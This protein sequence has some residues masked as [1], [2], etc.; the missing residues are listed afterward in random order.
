M[1][2]PQSQQQYDNDNSRFRIQGALSTL[3]KIFQDGIDQV[4]NEQL[5]HVI[6][7]IITTHGGSCIDHEPVLALQVLHAVIPVFPPALA[8]HVTEYT[9]KLWQWANVQQQHHPEVQSMVEIRTIQSWVCRNWNAVLAVR[10]EH[11]AHQ[12]PR[13]AHKVL[14]WTQKT[15]ST[16]HNKND[17]NNNNNNTM[18]TTA[19]GDD[20]SFLE[21]E[22]C[23]FWLTFCTLDED[24]LSSSF[25]DVVRNPVFLQGL[26]HTLL[27][28]M[29]YDIDKQQELLWM[30]AQEEQEQQ[31]QLLLLL[32]QNGPNPR[33]ALKPIF[34]R[35]RSAHNQHHHH[36]TS[37]NKHDEPSHMLDGHDMN[38]DDDDDDDDDDESSNGRI[39]GMDDD[40]DDEEWTVRKCAAATLDSLAHLYGRDILPILLP[41]ISAGLSA[42]NDPWLQEASILALGAVADGCREDIPHEFM[43]QVYGFLLDILFQS[44]SSSSAIVPPSLVSMAAWT[45]SQFAGFC[46]HQVQSGQDPDLLRKTTDILV[47]RLLHTPSI[48]KV[49]VAVASALAMLVEAA[50]D[51]MAPYLEHLYRSLVV[52]LN[53]FQGRS[54]LTVFDVFGILAEHGGPSTADVQLLSIYVP[55][56]LQMWGMRAQHEPR[57]RILLPLMESLSS[58][59]LAAGGNFTEYALT[60]FDNS[61]SMIESVT[62]LLVGTDGLTEEEVDPI[63]CAIDLIDAL[64]E[65]LS[66]SFVSLLNGSSRYGPHFLNVLLRMCQHEIAGVRMSALAVLGD[67]TRQAPSVI[68]PA[69]APLLEEA[70]K[71]MDPIQPKVAMN[72]VWAIG[73]ICVRCEGNDAILLPY[74]AD[75]LQNLIGLLMGNNGDSTRGTTIPGLCENA[76][77]CAGR[78]AKCNPNFVAPDLPRFLLGWCDGLAKVTDPLERRDAFQGF[79]K[80]IYVNPNA[81]QQAAPNVAD[82]IVSILFAITTWHLPDDFEHTSTQVLMNHEY[83]FEPFPSSESELGAALVQMVRDLKSSVNEQTWH[84]V[85]KSLPVNVR[86]LFR[87]NY[88]L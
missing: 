83:R 3:L 59:A 30:A 11:L 54:L 68:E 28:Q 75:I 12:F 36:S 80:T 76:A 84:S 57:D 37:S 71:S 35:S 79:V 55:S 33:D 51:W 82:T 14:E 20:G 58:I 25:H 42:V 26:I 46:M 24:A 50:G 9:N 39:G 18:T 63:I 52:C 86:R 34:Y 27:G 65:G 5:D 8:A 88:N 64:V 31:Q 85:T 60:C 41:Q 45:I 7:L 15:K 61:M 73:E 32:F 87:E 67:L 21:L 2:Q 13:L 19:A 74:A 77:A 22:A 4:S 44:C 16:G 40:D 81:I 47:S 62:L 1:L 70:V 69:L 23:D 38:H 48:C 56:L 78:L 53:T 17:N 6:P 66:N 29:V 72:A 49:Q 10:S 43:R